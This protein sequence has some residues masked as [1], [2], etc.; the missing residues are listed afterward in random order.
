MV[1]PGLIYVMGY[2]I[3]PAFFMLVWAAV[4]IGALLWMADRSREPLA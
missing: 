2:D 1:A 3:V 4:G